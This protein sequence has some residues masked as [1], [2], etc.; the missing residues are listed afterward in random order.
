LGLPGDFVGGEVERE[1]ARIRRMGKANRG[2]IVDDPIGAG[3]EKSLVVG[4]SANGENAGASRFAGTRAGRRIFDDDA[5]LRGEMEGGGAFGV[6]FGVW[7][8]V[9]NVAGGDEMMDVFPQ[10]G[11]AKTDFG[12][13]TGGGGDDGELAGSRGGE[14]VFGAGKRDDVGD[15]FD[16]GTLHPGVFG[17][18]DGGVGVREEFTDGGEAGAAVGEL[19]SGVGVEIMFAGPA[20]PDT[21]DG[22]SGVDKNAI[23]VDEEASAGDLDHG[24]ILAV[25]EVEVG[26]REPSVGLAFVA[27]GMV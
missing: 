21:G 22:G 10:S 1:V 6:G 17:K 26:S 25:N 20:D 27:S 4:G 14:Q 18:V 9:V 3:G 8:A 13:G 24:D 11:G 15:V 23:H 19:D 5:I 16:F 2:A 7:L 12:E